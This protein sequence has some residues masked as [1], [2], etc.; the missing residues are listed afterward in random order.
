[1]HEATDRQTPT[2]FYVNRGKAFLAGVVGGG[3]YVVI[4]VL[5]FVLPRPQVTARPWM[6]DEPL[7]TL[8]FGAGLLVS[9]A[10]VLMGLY[11]TFTSSPLLE[12]SSTGITYQPYPLVRRVV[13]WDDMYGI[14]VSTASWKSYFRRVT[15][16]T[17]SFRLKPHAAP[18]YRGRTQLV[19][20]IGQAALPVPI[21]D[22]VRTVHRYHQVT[23]AK[24]LRE[25]RLP[26]S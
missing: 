14:T 10:I 12:L 6:Y 13:R 25:G 1:M 26:A 15:R 19:W 20:N 8:I 21:D 4:F 22:V 11:W 23:A 17:I 3:V 9:G 7:K 24:H 16:L 18:L 2:R 5:A